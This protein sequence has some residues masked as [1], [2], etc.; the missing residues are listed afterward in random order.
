MSCCCLNLGYKLQ[1]RKKN[2]FKQGMRLK[3][4]KGEKKNIE[5]RYKPRK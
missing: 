2:G 4:L 3:A 1:R 5:N